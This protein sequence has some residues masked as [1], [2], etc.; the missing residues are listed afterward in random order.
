MTYMVVDC[1]SKLAVK[2]PR[3]GRTSYKTKASALR[4]ANW[5]TRYT[6]QVVVVMSAADYRAQVP[7]REVVSLMSGRKV[8]IDADTPLSCDPSSETYWSM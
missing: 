8:I 6:P 7:K 2:H 4:R 5:L 3:S 1:E